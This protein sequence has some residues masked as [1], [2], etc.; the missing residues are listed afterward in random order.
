MKE[1]IHK[2]YLNQQKILHGGKGEV[3]HNHRQAV[4]IGTEQGNIGDAIANRL[5]HS[6]GFKD[7]WTPSQQRLDV[8]SKVMCD[9]FFKAH[10]DVDTL[11]LSHGY[12]AMDWFENMPIQEISLIFETN[13]IGTALA[14]QSFVQTT[15]DA[16]YRKKIVVIGS[17]AHRSVLNA[18][19]AYCA[20]KAGVAHLVRCL[21]WELTPKAYDVF[22]VH[23]SNTEGTPMTEKTIKEIRRYRDFNSDEE[24]HEYWSSV[25]L[26]SRFLE[27]GDIAEVVHFLI[28]NPSAKFLSGTQIELSGGQ[29]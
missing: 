15:L 16:N 26:F 22:C 19:A 21:G 28:T 17:M 25:N 23:P 5:R 20:S 6:A 7:V 8:R 14:I 4:V 2:S 18:S 24:A 3:H 13:L 11:V 10:D 27:T 1:A 29:R 9:T 12:T